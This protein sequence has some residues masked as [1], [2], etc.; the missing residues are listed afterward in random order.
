MPADPMEQDAC[1][2]R[3]GSERREG[4]LVLALRCGGTLQTCPVGSQDG[5]P[6]APDVSPEG[7]DMA[8]GIQGKK[9]VIP[10]VEHGR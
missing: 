7:R 10:V 2:V 3:V 8:L 6:F 5:Q 1:R 9:E 4:V